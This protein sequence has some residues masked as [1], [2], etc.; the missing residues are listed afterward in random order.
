MDGLLGPHPK[1]DSKFV[2]P[3]V[4]LGPWHCR[5]MEA[6]GKGETDRQVLARNQSSRW[7]GRYISLEKVGKPFISWILDKSKQIFFYLLAEELPRLPRKDMR[8]IT[9]LN[10]HNQSLFEMS[11]VFLRVIQTDFTV[12]SWSWGTSP[13]GKCRA[14]LLCGL[15]ETG[16]TVV[17]MGE[18]ECYGITYQ[19]TPF[20]YKP[21]LDAPTSSKIYSTCFYAQHN[22]L[23]TSAKCSE[24]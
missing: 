6:A 8:K 22:Y 16:L 9:L 12:S 1:E 24:R 15:K 4:Y 21:H 23:S 7:D 19:Y 17:S 2:P 18:K 14:L 20:L 3:N 11:G 5:S 13:L 10:F